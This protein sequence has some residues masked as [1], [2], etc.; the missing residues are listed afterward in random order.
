MQQASDEIEEE[1]LY[2][3]NAST[4]KIEKDRVVSEAPD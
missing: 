3:F 2:F 1:V 4:Q